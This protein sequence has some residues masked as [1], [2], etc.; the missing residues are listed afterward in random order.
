MDTLEGPYF[1]YYA[2]ELNNIS[3]NGQLF[4]FNNFFNPDP[5]TAVSNGDTV[6]FARLQLRFWTRLYHKDIELQGVDH[7]RVSVF[8]IKNQE[9]IGEIA[10][11]TDPSNFFK[12][13]DQD[14]TPDL[15]HPS[16]TLN[17]V[18][19]DREEFFDCLYDKVIPHRFIE[20]HVTSINVASG[21]S[22]EP[23]A[24]NPQFSNTEW[25]NKMTMGALELP[26]YQYHPHCLEV[27]I[28]VG[29]DVRFLA[30]GEMYPFFH[31]AYV[32]AGE[33][34]T[35]PK[36]T[37]DQPISFV[38]CTSTVTYYLKKKETRVSRVEA[39]PSS[40]KKQKK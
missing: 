32:A 38:S 14:S 16:V 33:S 29:E 17:Y 30:N 13:F 34:F 19:K 37:S 36:H 6:H 2:T 1:Y 18:R 15:A 11:I 3:P 24:Q 28:P 31:F 12:V 23:D 9:R 39:A 25:Q 7:F 40:Q 22:T 10:K 35:Y 5:P 26:T 8:R 4:A 20:K 27:D 21:G